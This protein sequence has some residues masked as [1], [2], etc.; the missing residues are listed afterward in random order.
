VDTHTNPYVGP[1]TFT[2]EDSDRFYGRDREAGDLLSLVLAE[3]LVLFYAQSG[4]GKSSLVNARLIPALRDQKFE[5]LPVARVSGAIPDGIDQAQIDNIFIFNLLLAVNQELPDELRQPPAALAGLTLTRFLGGEEPSAGADAYQVLPTALII[6]QFEE[7]VTTHL[8]RWQDRAGFFAQVSQAM[9]DHP[10][11]WVVL[12]MREDFVAALDPYVHLL[13]GRLRTRF[14]MERMGIDAALEAVQKPAAQA[15][16]PFTPAAA[17][18]LV[19]NLRQVRIQGQQATVLGEYVEPVQL[20]V[21]CYQIWENIQAAGKAAIT[22]EDLHKLGDVD[23]ALGRFYEEALA[24]ALQVAPQGVTEQQLRTWFDEKLLTEA[25]T[26]GTVYQGSDD[27]E[28]MPN[29]VIDVLA[30]RFLLRPV[31]RAGGTWY[32]LIHDRMIDPI[33][34]ANRDWRRQHQNPLRV[35]AER[36]SAEGQR[37]RLVA[38][39]ETLAGFQKQIEQNPQ[40]FS[41]LERHFVRESLRTEELR[42]ELITAQRLAVLERE[43]YLSET[44]W[45]V[46]FPSNGE[47][48]VREALRKLLEHRRSQATAKDTRCYREFY[49]TED[50]CRPDETARSF[51]ERHG[52]G[53]GKGKPQIMPYYLLLVGSPEEISYSFQ[54]QL[55]IDYAVGRIHFD[56]PDEYR[57]YAAGVVAAERQE[58]TRPRTAALFLPQYGDLATTNYV[59]ERSLPTI[60]AELERAR[61]GWTVE[62]AAGHQAT[63]VRLGELLAAGRTPAVL[64]AA[65]QGVRL[66]GADRRRRDV[67]GSLFC[68]VRGYETTSPENDPNLYFSAADL[69]GDSQVQGLVAILAFSNSLGTPRYDGFAHRAGGRRK[70]DVDRPFVARLAQRLLG[71]PAGSALAVIGRIERSGGVS[72]PGDPTWAPVGEHAFLEMLR[73]LLD[74]FPVGA[75]LDPLNRRYAVLAADLFEH[76]NSGPAGRIANQPFIESLRANVVEMRSWAIAGDP[77]VRVAV[78]D[79]FPAMTGLHRLY[80]SEALI[81]SARDAA[82]AGDLAVAVA[83]FNDAL[84]ANPALDL[85]PEREARRMRVR[86]LVEEGRTLAGQGEVGKATAIL[87]EARTLDPQAGIEPARVMA[88]L[89]TFAFLKEGERLAAN[90][91]VSAAIAQFRR[92]MQYDPSLSIDPASRAA[93]IATP[94]FLRAGRATAA[95]GDVAKATTCFHRAVELSPDLNIDP[96]IEAK[97][98][99]AP[100]WYEEGSQLAA[101]GDEKGAVAAFRRVL[102]L[103]PQAG[104][105]PTARAAE[106]AAKAKAQEM[107]EQGRQQMKAGK[108]AEATALFR[109]AQKLDATLAIDPEQEA[110]RVTGLLP[111]FGLKKK[112]W[113]PGTVLRV[114]FLEGDPAVQKK[115]MEAALE[116]TKYA[117]IQFKFGDDPDAEIRITFN[118]GLG[119]WAY[120]GTDALTVPR[121]QP[122]VNYGWLTPDSP[123]T[124]YTGSVLHTFGRVLALTNEHQSPNATIQWN[125]EAVYKTFTGPP[126]YWSKEQV[127]FNLLKKYSPEAMAVVKEFDPQSIMM[128]PIP[129]ELTLDGLAYGQNPT[130]SELDKEAIGRL[131][132]F[133]EAQ[134]TSPRKAKSPRSTAP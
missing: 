17:S 124:E 11:L 36:W 70:R 102:E 14:Y 85:D 13:P 59:A 110:R 134:A 1:R 49:G 78:P 6:D 107:V 25:G 76:L 113:K 54:Y 115:V 12:V 5:V 35:A 2:R 130:L 34:T 32:E 111:S 120:L 133:G 63:K 119:S 112:V 55:D 46:I 108:T 103:D 94:F 106:L 126:N 44:G 53:P 66:A 81:R 86:T 117:N 93:E 96:V 56:T 43:K 20:Q 28:G 60:Q 65:G 104:F 84:D 69:A 26:R 89:A 122:T 10:Q 75:V 109:R 97:R 7:I 87:E 128:Y 131:Y 8:D 45:G 23:R 90:G 40:E 42:R 83:R 64:F 31:V 16:C 105:D 52:A 67:E 88:E 24:A 62:S 100:F 73:L 48:A 77:A 72:G 33:V 58:V 127:E 4:A 19:D 39:G 121:E 82:G 132:P 50:G 92:A 116:W 57:R 30:R 22:G 21:V 9:I 18:E 41:D 98:R 47:P 79:I 101:R 123:A 95:K 91:K 118:T 61:G 80:E 74:G 114:R 27:T 29:S 125:L 38:T 99:A 68:A 3:R 37:T 71:H 129:K 15:G 51:L